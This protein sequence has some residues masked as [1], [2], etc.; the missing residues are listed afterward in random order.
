VSESEPKSAVVL[1]LAE[2]FIDRYRKGE[3]PP[4][5]EY[6]DRHPELAAEI[7]DVFPAMAMMENI[8]LADDS[9]ADPSQGPG[10]KS[11]KGQVFQQL[12]D[13]RLIREVGRGGMG[14]VYEAEQ[15]SL[16]RHVALKVLPDKA[17]LDPKHKRRFE[18][19][20][21]AAA[22]LHHTNI[23]PV[24]EV[25]EDR[26]ICF[27]AMQLIRGQGLDEIID[28]LRRL[29]SHSLAGQ[30]VRSVKGLRDRAGAA[31]NEPDEP[32]CP[33]LGE[34]TL[35]LLSGHFSAQPLDGPERHAEV[36]EEPLAV[37]A[38]TD[39][40]ASGEG[41]SGRL[42]VDG[43]AGPPS[44][45]R[46]PGQTDLS[47]LQSNY[48]HYFHS[49]ARIG[50][51]TADA[52]AYAHARGIVHR[53]IKPSNLL[54][55]AAGVVWVTDFGLAKTEDA[56][57]TDTGDV[58]GTLRYMAPERFAGEC[59]VTADVYSL[60]LTLYELLVLKSAFDSRDRAQLISMVQK[61]EP[62]PPRALDPRIPRDLETI[63]LKAIEKE[64][65]RRYQSAELLAEDLRRFIADEPIKARQVNRVERLWRWCHRNPLV[66]GLS[67]GIA[68][69]LLVVAVAS[70][71][72]AFRF[73][74]L[75]ADE[76]AA[77]DDAVK[78]QR[79]A[80]RQQTLAQ[81]NFDQAR[82]AVNDY[83]T[84]VSENRLLGV[85]GLQPLRK[86]L[87]ESALKYYQ[88]FLRQ[89][90]NDPSLEKELAEAY[91]R[92]ARITAEIGPKTE[93]LAIYDKAIELRKKSQSQ[94]PKDL[95]LQLDLVDHHLAVGTLQRQ[96]GDHSSALKSS[97][98]AYRIL[99]E[100]SPQDPNK[101]V[102]IKL[103]TRTQI[104]K[105]PVHTSDNLDILTRFFDVLNEIGAAH[106]DAGQKQLALHYYVEAVYVQKTL[107][108]DH[109]NDPRIGLFKQA[110]ARQWNRLG[111]VQGALGLND[112]GLAYHEEARG[113]LTDLQRE[114][115]RYADEVDFQRELADS[116][117]SIGDLQAKMGHAGPAVESYRQALPTR[118]RL[119]RESPA[120]T[121][122]QGDLARTYFAIGQLHAR[123]NET[124][125]AQLSFQQA[126]ERQRLL[127]ATAPQV[128]Q[129]AH[130]LG[131]LY[132]ELARTYRQV[133]KPG[134]ARATYEQ[135]RD[136]L[137]K[138]P[139]A[140]AEE[141]HRLALVRAGCSA[142]IGGDKPGTTAAE[143]AE[144]NRL[145]DL[146]VDALRRAVT[147]GFKDLEQL[148]TD[149]ELDPLRAREDF[150]KLV[151]ELEKQASIL[152]WTQDLEAA[153]AQAAREK[154]DLFLF[155]GGSDW[156]PFDRALR[157][158]YLSKDA[159]R[160]YLSKH[161]LVVEFDDFQYKPK[162]KNYPTRRQLARKW[163]INY[164]PTMVLTDAG[165]RPYAIVLGVEER[166]PVEA[167]LKRLESSRQVR[168]TRDDCLSKAAGSTGSE[169]AQWLLKGLS[170]VPASGLV[171]YS[172]EL[173]EIVKLAPDESAR[174]ASDDPQFWI[175]RG[176][177][178]AQSGQFDRQ[179]ADFV[180]ALDLRPH[181]PLVVTP[182][183]DAARDLVEQA[184]KPAADA[185]DAAKRDQQIRA[186]RALYEKLITIEPEGAP[187]VDPLANL[188]MQDASGWTVLEP[189]EM[190]S[191]GDA[192]L[193]RLPDGSVRAG[194]K[195]PDREVY[196]ITLK[197]DL[198]SIT[199]IRLD[200]LPDPSLP[201]QGPGRAENGGFVLTRL[202][203]ET[204]GQRANWSAAVAS[205]SQPGFPVASSIDSKPGWAIMP[206]T[207]RP[208]YAIFMLKA[209]LVVDPARP[210]TIRVHC[211][212]PDMPRRALGRF[213]LSATTVPMLPS[214]MSAL[215]VGPWTR[216]GAAYA[217]RGEWGRALAALQAG[218]G[219]DLL[220]SAAIHKELGRPA[221]ARQAFDR[222]VAWMARSPSDEELLRLAVDA[223][224][225]R[226]ERQE[227]TAKML[228]VRARWQAQLG[229]QAQ[230]LA[231]LASAQALDALPTFGPDD[232]PIVLA[233][234]GAAADKGDWERAAVELARAIALQPKNPQVLGQLGDCTR[235][236]CAGLSAVAKK[237]QAR[238]AS[239]Q[240]QAYLE[241]LV[242][243]EPGNAAHAR[244]LAEFL[245]QGA[246]AWTVLEPADMKSAGGAT[247][248]RQ[249]DN[250]I[251]AGGTNPNAEV[252][253]VRAHVQ[254]PRIT[255][256]R[257]EVIPDPSLPD[258]AAGRGPSGNFVLNEL[259]V[260]LTDGPKADRQVPV[261]LADAT[262]TS[263]TWA[264]VGNVLDRNNQSVWAV[265]YGRW[266]ERQ[267]A[268][269]EV[270]PVLDAATERMLV[271]HL[272]CTHPHAAGF[273]IGR[274]RLSVTSAASPVLA[275]RLLNVARESPS[276]LT[277]LA[278]AYG[279]RGDWQAAQRTLTSAPTPANPA[280]AYDH[281]LLALAYEHLGRSVESRKSFDEGIAW[282]VKSPGDRPPHELAVEAASLLLK[283]SPADASL[284]L[285][286]GR[287][288]T[289]L[290]LK[291][292]ALD[293]LTKVIEAQPNSTEAW[294]AR[295]QVYLALN[296]QDQAVRDYTRALEIDP[297][298]T[299]ARQVRAN[300]Y[301]NQKQWDE[302]VS[303]FGKLVEVQPENQWAWRARCNIFAH[304][305]QWRLATAEYAKLA[306]L[307]N[308]AFSWSDQGLQAT[309]LLGGGDTAGYRKACAAMLE[310]FKDTQDAWA[311]SGTAQTCTLAPDAVPH[312]AVPLRLARLAVER[313]AQT[314]AFK[315]TLAAVLYRA[316]ELEEAIK[317]FQA[318]P[319]P[320]NPPWYS[321]AHDRLYLAMA[322]HRLGR[323]DQAR[324]LLQKA[325][326]DVEQ[327]IKRD[328]DNYFSWNRRLSL[329]LLRS[330][331]EQLLAGH[332][333]PSAADK[334]PAPPK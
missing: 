88:G 32:G 300:L 209:P 186:C 95:Q 11:Q 161:F 292:L 94:G 66:A 44:S 26:E 13:Y 152:V 182:V 36:E 193:A 306:S 288:F 298:D 322:N 181:D 205:Y 104:S 221:E 162:P 19:E 214:F 291:Q 212:W 283:Q 50:Q 131:R 177:V 169:K 164:C 247:L 121:D 266:R 200:A 12:G 321:M 206:Q 318:A 248:T 260:D 87:L 146:A 210:T 72:A 228:L 132:Q 137:E 52:L 64:P 272:N 148:D 199:G 69:L 171:D 276:G 239:D 309:A 151:Q 251:L 116:Y 170:G 139:S 295:A 46:L 154:K 297:K 143:R 134:E 114:H 218:T 25:G 126:I 54:L 299:N 109:P 1:A 263:P 294:T 305:R 124:A 281:F 15:V 70:T 127:V 269:F 81:E 329:Q 190:R 227:K 163:T 65:R 172:E 192:T 319:P 89:H 327:E 55:D 273:A 84:K 217:L 238:K 224:S 317:Q 8:A 9:L 78:A 16:G 215:G 312:F 91:T 39:A 245:V 252:Y 160:H 117:E 158:T 268:V 254:V 83:L 189:A 63:V 98:E 101:E 4:L 165:A 59:D 330:E 71:V 271:F 157:E 68:A 7:R 122:Y 129:Y 17:R 111:R 149:R 301:L 40:H 286:R 28:E 184:G 86:E 284:R 315:Q 67:A 90:A 287:W 194:G 240:T 311:A 274:F 231:D 257:L 138:L 208:Q 85:P 179:A 48:R 285:E 259:M 333:Q 49:V 264:G 258:S 130:F 188:L 237:D 226:I 334:Y 280:T 80:E 203:L 308:Q 108:A 176:R 249:S 60:G 58:V 323:H 232:A 320:G 92:M 328:A 196:T 310:R 296:Q 56:A 18:R 29:R 173:Q 99:K 275:A 133:N 5:R 123:A 118:E 47:S 10:G 14:I 141:L 45:A 147:A 202:V 21:R 43:T 279:L 37:G 253:T 103:A 24:F 35:S 204:K 316:G 211:E 302:A 106:A 38:E 61:D 180:K 325:L 220:L 270:Q 79:E 153:K 243:A 198:K 53:D 241:K 33:K 183:A 75:A 195:N 144:R 62:A 282:L 223:V 250:S 225:E 20:A 222:A 107:V 185:A 22:K 156:C 82:R 93:A 256:I 102:Q 324:R 261:L 230:A 278:A 178:F 265:A 113:T 246:D 159:V 100:V 150:K 290:G 142:L 255:G 304:R 125:A 242:T 76:R 213:R 331:A 229:R 277:R 140:D 155:F 6:I 332:A 112:E 166:E 289:R 167:F 236:V 73:R 174:L 307:V 115:T 136:L 120:V 105:V 293:D 313:Q 97:E 119:A 233:Q 41:A 168:I 197:T 2:E 30:K 27:Y 42:R 235:R 262:A 34:A 77:R 51:Q 145:A 234:A 31:E 110:L 175:T 267:T 191:A 128:R 3:R 23:V 303:D 216:L 207:S 135:A 326:T 187:Y 201:N 219:Y 74:A 244:Q 57:L 314:P 96:L